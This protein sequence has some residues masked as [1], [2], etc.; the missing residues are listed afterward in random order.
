MVISTKLPK[1]MVVSLIW[2]FCVNQVLGKVPTNCIISVYSQNTLVTAMWVAVDKEGEGDG[3][4]GNG[5]EGK[6]W[7][8]GRWQWQERG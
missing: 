5:D 8:Q 3:S 7:Q 1:E 4:K 6:Q 2:S